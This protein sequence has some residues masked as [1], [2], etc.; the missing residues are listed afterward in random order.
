MSNSMFQAI[1][2][3]NTKNTTLTYQLLLV[4][5]RTDPSSRAGRWLQAS[6]SITR[7]LELQLCNQLLFDLAVFSFV[8]RVAHKQT[9]KQKEETMREIVAH[10]IFYVHAQSKTNNGRENTRGH[11][12]HLASL[13][14]KPQTLAQ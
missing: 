12:A 11:K 14:L 3:E 8:A 7:S 10:R 1:Q 2:N 5:F 13:R 4:L 9:K 6:Q